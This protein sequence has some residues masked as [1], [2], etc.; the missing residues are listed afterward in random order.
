MWLYFCTAPLP[1]Q[2]L[3]GKIKQLECK[4]LF[5]HRR[6][7]CGPPGSQT[8]LPSHLS[9][10]HFLPQVP[11]ATPSEKQ[12]LVFGEHAGNCRVDIKSRKETC[13]MAK[14]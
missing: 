8:L 13:L 11:K 2:M 6:Y 3:S 12:S 14:P 9:D 7:P 10:P 4:I 5:G 1:V